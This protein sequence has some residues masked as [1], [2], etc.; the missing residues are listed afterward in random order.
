MQML[1]NLYPQKSNNNNQK[2]NNNNQ[3][4]STNQIG[5]LIKNIE[6]INDSLKYYWSANNAIS[7]NLERGKALYQHLLEKEISFSYSLFLNI[8]FS[9][10]LVCKRK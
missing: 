9:L 5:S 4:N 7:P 10:I 6:S 3:N 8:L 2:S 1:L